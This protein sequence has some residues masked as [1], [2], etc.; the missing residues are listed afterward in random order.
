MCKKGKC[1]CAVMMVCVATAVA[2]I[3]CNKKTSAK[4]QFRKKVDEAVDTAIDMIEQAA[5][6]AEELFED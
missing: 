1:V 6:R 3:C 2:M 4:K 5:Q